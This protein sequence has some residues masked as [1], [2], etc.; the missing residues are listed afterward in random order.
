MLE[1]LNEI[2]EC[3]KCKVYNT[4][5]L[6]VKETQKYLKNIGLE[7]DIPVLTKELIDDNEIYFYICPTCKSLCYLKDKEIKHISEVPTDLKKLVSIKD[8]LENDRVPYDYFHNALKDN[9][10]GI[11]NNVCSSDS[12]KNIILSKIIKGINV[13]ELIS[14]IENVDNTNTKYWLFIKEDKDFIPIPINSKKDLVNLIEVSKSDLNKE[15][16]CLI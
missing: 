9:D 5:N 1:I 4:S 2:F 13:S 14:T 7:G 12:M 10:I 6:W 8:L 11:W 3:R 15:I 16:L